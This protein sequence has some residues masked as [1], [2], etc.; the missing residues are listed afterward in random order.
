[1]KTI[2]SLLL[3]MGL[4][5]HGYAQN[6]TSYQNQLDLIKKSENQ[7]KVGWIFLGGGLAMGI[8]SLAI[9]NSYDYNTGQSNTG[10]LATLGW[11]SAISI[12]VSIPIF[13]SSGS[14][15]RIAAKL[16]LQNQALYQPI[17]ST[18]QPKNFLSI[19]LKIPF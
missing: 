18:G 12:A 1:M 8:T 10:G 11:A 2:F 5:I 14:N 9:P 19:N 13:L 15:A 6:S 3:V 7:Y 16:G 17:P 4:V